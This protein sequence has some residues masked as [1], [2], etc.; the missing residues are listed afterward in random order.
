M[1]FKDNEHSERFNK[2]LEAWSV[3]SSDTYRTALAYLIALDAITY[4][5]HDELYDN[6]DKCIIPEGIYA[7][8]QTGTTTKLTR[9]AFNL[10]TAS[11]LWCNDDELF[12]CS[13]DAIFD[14]SYAPYFTEALKIRF[15]CYF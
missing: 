8:W 2:L 13:P 5:H 14:C 6:S 10:F 12:Y 9:L 11:L 3:N 15:S 4:K 1:L 7:A